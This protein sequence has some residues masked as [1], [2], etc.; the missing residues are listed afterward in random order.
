[1]CI[2]LSVYHSWGYADLSPSNPLHVVNSQ[3]INDYCGIINR[4]LGVGGT[5]IM[6]RFRNSS[7]QDRVLSSGDFISSGEK[8]WI[9]TQ[10]C[11]NI[12]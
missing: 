6:I 10:I 3:L 11:E 7:E 2:I 4:I 8:Q 1:M 9:N 5:V 12:S